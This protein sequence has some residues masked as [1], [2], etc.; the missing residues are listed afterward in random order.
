MNAIPHSLA[1]FA[2]WMRDRG[3]RTRGEGWSHR[4]EL[5]FELMKGLV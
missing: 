5:W 1:R 4:D 2:T 3:K